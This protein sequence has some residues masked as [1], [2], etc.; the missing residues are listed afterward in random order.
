M[1]KDDM[2][3]VKTEMK[4]KKERKQERGIESQIKGIRQ[5]NSLITSS[6]SGLGFHGNVYMTLYPAEAKAGMAH[7]MLNPP[8]TWHNP[9]QTN[10][11][12]PLPERLGPQP[13][14]VVGH[15]LVEGMTM[16]SFK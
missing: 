9:S 15:L 7:I 4:G 12:Y 2:K 1:R 11:L 10:I 5:L 13:D 16:F 8:F 3:T 6:H 14:G